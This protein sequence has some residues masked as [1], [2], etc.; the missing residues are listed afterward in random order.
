MIVFFKQSNGLISL[1]ETVLH[2]ANPEKFV[3][4]KDNIDLL[5]LKSP[6]I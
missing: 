1:E 2:L 3:F 6:K 4:V 5:V